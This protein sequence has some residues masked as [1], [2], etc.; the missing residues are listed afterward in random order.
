M[1]SK[2]PGLED[3]SV[4]DGMSSDYDLKTAAKRFKFGLVPKT[5]SELQQTVVHE[6]MAHDVYSM[7]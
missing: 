4:K 7:V 1:K 6:L 5:A 3:F 2:L